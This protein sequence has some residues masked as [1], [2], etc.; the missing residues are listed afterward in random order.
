M[1]R[2]GRSSHRENSESSLWWLVIKMGSGKFWFAMC[3]KTHFVVIYLI[4][5]LILT[6]SVVLLDRQNW[7]L[8]VGALQKIFTRLYWPGAHRTQ[9]NHEVQSRWTCDRKTI[10]QYNTLGHFRRSKE[11][12]RSLMMTLL[13][14]VLFISLSMLEGNST[15]T[16]TFCSK[17]TSI[18]L[19]RSMLSMTLFIPS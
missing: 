15:S 18:K 8:Q 16:L 13:D 9:T 10:F 2:S 6:I 1:P 3:S 5:W 12:R 7:K 14:M 11:C 17:I 4:S 19:K